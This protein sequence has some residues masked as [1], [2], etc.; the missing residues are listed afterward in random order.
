MKTPCVHVAI[1]ALDETEWLPHCLD[2]LRKQSAPISKVWICVNQPDSWWD[3]PDL[4]DACERNAELLAWLEEPRGLDVE[5]IDRSSPGRGWTG[6]RH[7]VGWARKTLMDAISGVADDS[8]VIVSADA[9]A[10][11]TGN[12][13]QQVVQALSG[14]TAGLA[15]AAPY[16]H[17][18][19][20]DATTV[21]AGL[22][23]E[24]YLRYYFLNMA[25]IGSPYTFTAMGSLISLPVGTYRAVG[26]LE[27]RQGAE[28][29]YFLQKIRKR[30]R[31]LQWIDAEV[32]PSARLSNRVPIGTGPAI[33]SGIDG[34]WD[35]YPLYAPQWFDDVQATINA[36]PAL[37]ECDAETPMSEFLRARLGTDDI[38]GPM[39]RNHKDRDRFVRACHERVDG[40]RTLQFLK[41]RAAMHRVGD[42]R[43][44]L[45][46]L[47]LTETGRDAAPDW[48]LGF[49]GWSLASVDIDKLESLVDFM[50]RRENAWRR[51][52]ASDA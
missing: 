49:P 37:H 7:G 28:D 22:R 1:P 39:R 11:Y 52:E 2:S 44:L 13:I 30:G 42:E 43:N 19:V 34:H 51:R 23:Y 16:R 26:G 33:R 25:R 18:Q 8:D 31:L 3:D 15:L 36:F 6:K 48:V 10:W 5:I 14:A 38:W 27:P 20:Q 24:I 17:A 21:R 40:L 35:R 4:R 47:K 45:D 29:F 50:R 46:F 9:D 12:Y 32:L 41:S